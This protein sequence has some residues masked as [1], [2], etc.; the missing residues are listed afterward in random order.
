MGAEV[1]R[2][3]DIG[4]EAAG[5]AE[6]AE[7]PPDPDA[8]RAD[9]D[10]IEALSAGLVPPPCGRRD[11]CDV[12]DE[13][14]A[15]LAGWVADIRPETLLH[16]PGDRPAVAGL[17]TPPPGTPI[18]GSAGSDL[19]VPGIP[20]PRVPLSRRPSI[21]TPNI[22]T[23]NTR[24][25]GTVGAVR[26]LLDH[27]DD[28]TQPISIVR[29]RS[30]RR[31]YV[32]R[33]AAAVMAVA[34]LVSGV[35]MGSY[36]A[37]PGEPLWSVAQMVFP[38]KSRSVAA[39]SA[40]AGAL[41]T[42][43]V[44]LERGRI[45]DAQ[46]AF[47]SVQAQLAVID[48]ADGKGE[49]TEQTAYLDAQLDSAAAGPAG[50]SPVSA[51]SAPER[52]LAVGQAGALIPSNSTVAPG[53]T[54]ALASTT[55]TLPVLAAQPAVSR[56]GLPPANTGTSTLAIAAPPG[57]PPASVPAASAP[58]VSA[59]AASTPGIPSGATVP[60][61][62]AGSAS[63][64]PPVGDPTSSGATASG[65]SGA[66]A[67][68]DP[69]ASTPKSSAA[70]SPATQPPAS[71]ST[72]PD[73]IVDSANTDTTLDDPA[74]SAPSREPAAQSPSDPTSDSSAREKDEPSTQ[75][76]SPSTAD[77]TDD[78]TVA[79]NAGSNL[80]DTTSAVSSTDGSS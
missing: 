1:L 5:S 44:A 6:D 20:G 54:L 74:A 42:A 41:N 22:Q 60:A 69:P 77:P 7:Q 28:H 75:D 17:R 32:V 38:A 18:V 15:L 19:N 13:L 4:D 9:D 67:T 37:H 43:R 3:G 16:R 2:A 23:P 48:D 61:P 29:R 31:T 40:V 33:A 58:A 47:R 79:G 30:G 65:P 51:T 11:P 59:P 68:T 64:A 39:A 45:G 36:D 12:E 24:M 62:P 76:A 14:V 10:L 53:A 55:P 80:G 78:V 8:V 70:D 72:V 34:L 63:V 57:A 52:P 56:P 25:P 49:L 66:T 46:V 35:L 27:D 26:S 71:D 21:H 73:P 50:V